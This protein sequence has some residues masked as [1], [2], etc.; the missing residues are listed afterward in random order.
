MDKGTR[1]NELKVSGELTSRHLLHINCSYTHSYLKVQEK[2]NQ[3]IS[4]Q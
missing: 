1:Y 3:G 2:L 4:H